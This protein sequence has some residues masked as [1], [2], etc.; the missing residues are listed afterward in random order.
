MQ[1]EGQ[2]ARVAIY[3]GESDQYRGKPLYMAILELLRRGGASGATVT[4]GLAG[5]GAHSR[6]RTASIV[7]LSTDLPI[8]V[9]WVDSQA[10]V[11]RLLPQVRA[12]VEDGLITLDTVSVIQ[13]APGRGRAP[14]DSPVQD[15]MRTEVA[16]VEP[17]TPVAEIVRL[18]LEHGMRSLP[19]VTGDTR[20]VGIITDG[21]L[22][23]RADLTA[24]LGL[25]TELTAAQI[26]SQIAQLQQSGLT[27]E[28]IMT[29]APVSV[30]TRDT[31]A[32]AA[33][34]MADRDLKRLPVLDDEGRLA[35]WLSRVDLFRTLDYYFAAT[36][37]PDAT[38]RSGA[39]VAALMTSNVATIGPQAR[40]EEIVQALE[41]T[42]TLRAVVVDDHRRVLGIITDG[43]LLRRSRQRNNPTLLR[44]LRRLL[45]GPAERDSVLPAGDER[46]VDLM[47]SP[48]ISVRA[49]TPLPR[50]L[51][52]MLQ[53]SI[54]RLPVVDESGHFLGL[55]GRASVL[56][57]L[58]DT[59]LGP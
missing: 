20:L 14:L 38:P 1:I 32:T 36:P 31:L 29:P 47:T 37:E 19:V 56:R 51:H 8:A 46:A 26:Q 3:I 21:D 10:R 11:E 48:V 40:L 2:A 39:S 23:R 33:K 54:K 6:I 22:L 30:R 16:S 55:L 42:R 34:L 13:Y 52:L 57:G 27:A 5:F 12:M 41:R 25:Q 4:R 44:R 15:V 45:G 7:D 18:L 24:R 35:G 49:E 50:A 58:L 28:A 43:D 17:S 59:P 9:V 53:H